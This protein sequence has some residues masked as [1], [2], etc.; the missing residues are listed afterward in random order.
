[1]N[2]LESSAP[3]TPGESL[4]DYVKRV[5]TSLSLTQKELAAKAGIHLQSLGKIERGRTAKLNRHSQNGLAYALQIPVEYLAAIC[6]GT[7]VAASASL[8]FCPHCWVPGT[9]PESIWMEVR[10]KY[11]FLCGSQ[12]Q[13]RC[14]Q[15][16]EPITSLK[17]RFCPYCGTAY[18]LDSSPTSKA[19]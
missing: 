11:C 13:Q 7:P 17:H 18:K 12:L 8:K 3:P 10:T 6:R 14:R 15:C 16:N 5:R 9:P 2:T 1:M 4:A 19:G